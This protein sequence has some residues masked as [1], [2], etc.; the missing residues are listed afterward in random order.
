MD[1]M[2]K[3]LPN[4]AQELILISGEVLGLF[5]LTTGFSRLLFRVRRRI[6]Q[7]DTVLEL[8]EKFEI[9]V[10]GRVYGHILKCKIENITIRKNVRA[11][12]Q[13]KVCY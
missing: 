13:R 1:Q 4:S 9:R 8:S 6:F 2:S 10:Y 11:I 5:E 12:N 7:L 3:F